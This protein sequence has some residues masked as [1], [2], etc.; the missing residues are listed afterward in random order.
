MSLISAS[1]ALVKISEG[2]I[3][4]EREVSSDIHRI[5]MQGQD[6]SQLI[7]SS[8]SVSSTIPLER[9]V[10]KVLIAAGNTIEALNN[11]QYQEGWE[12]V[13]THRTISSS[14]LKL[15]QHG[16][17]A[18]EVEEFTQEELLQKYRGLWR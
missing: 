11:L 13:H 1:G 6:I 17:F 3:R 8:C 7:R 16:V 5:A 2:V 4:E 12:F 10:S 15:I 14:P 18:R 9:V